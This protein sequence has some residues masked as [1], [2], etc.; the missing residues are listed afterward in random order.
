MN[1]TIA[2]VD[3]DTLVYSS[4]AV[5]EKRSVLVTHLPT[6]REKEFKN[7][8]EFKD[9]LKEKEF[10]FKQDDYS[11]KEV[12][13]PEPE[14]NAY[15]IISSKLKKIKSELEAD[16]FELYVA[17]KG[18]ERDLLPLP[19]KYKSNRDTTVRPLLLNKARDFIKRHECAIAIDGIEV[20]E[21]IV[22]RGY[23]ELEKGNTPVLVSVDKDSLQYSGLS[24]Y[25]YSNPFPKVE[26]IPKLGELY[27][28]KKT[29]KVK[30]KGFLWYCV[31]QTLGDRADGY[32]PYEL[33]SARYGDKAAYDYL[34]DSGN[35]KEALEKVIDLYKT[36]YPSEFKYTAWNGLEITADYKYMLC[37]YHKCSRMIEVEGESPDFIKFAKQ[38][39]IEL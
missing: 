16:R 10:E 28:D 12:Q 22:Y 6:G 2:L 38:Y 9:F 11:I 20:D 18:N 30:G 15:H 7:K 27:L 4:A 29:K 26:L 13:V 5:C 24:I 8:T 3:C 14:Q 21:V 32:I 1:K 34:K 35:E 19:T 37:L 39:G 31:Q 33:T 25:D 17:G 23:Q 36:W